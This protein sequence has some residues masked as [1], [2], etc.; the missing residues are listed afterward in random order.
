MVL[1]SHLAYDICR[2]LHEEEDYPA[3][4]AKRLGYGKDDSGRRKT[5]SVR[6]AISDLVE[7]SLLE[8]T[9]K[10]KYNRQYYQLDI[11][12]LMSRWAELWFERYQAAQEVYDSD[13]EEYENPEELLSGLG[14]DF[15]SFL[16]NR[17]IPVYLG[18]VEDSNLGNMLG[19]D[20]IDNMTACT[21]YISMYKGA[22]DADEEPR[23]WMEEAQRKLMEWHSA[24]REPRKSV[25]LQVIP[26]WRELGFSR[27]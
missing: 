23:N 25:A 7:N 9:R 14:D 3:N 24:G 4:I 17:Y 22:P 21:S 15:E 5:H 12:G 20:F 27:D 26:T 2:I 18:R 6:N 11:E 10:G 8:T 13:L 1:D 16:R 19:E